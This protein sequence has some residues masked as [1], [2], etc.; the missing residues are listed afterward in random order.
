MRKAFLV[1]VLALLIP[2]FAQV[3]QITAG[4]IYVGPTDDNGWT[5]AHDAARQMLDD[6]YD[7]LTTIAVE[8][9]PEADAEPFIDQLIQQGANVIF[10]TSFG[11]MDAT[12]AAAA[13]YPDVIRDVRGKG[14]LVGVG[15]HPNNRAFMAAARDQRLLLAGGGDNIV[16]LLPPLNISAREVDEILRRFD[17]TCASMALAAA[18]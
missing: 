4:F 14:M 10:T 2:A 3:E 8:S 12:I 13:R 9:V 11:F 6:E 1:A 16:R 15:V 7:W 5:E 17:A 18:S